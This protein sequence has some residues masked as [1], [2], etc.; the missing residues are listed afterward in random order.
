MAFL[1]EL[2]APQVAI[3]RLNMGID[4]LSM[5]NGIKRTVDLLMIGPRLGFAIHY[6]CHGS[7]FH[8]G[9]KRLLEH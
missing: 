9:P 8:H 1:K 4:S 5:Y 3:D 2:N 6:C 7:H